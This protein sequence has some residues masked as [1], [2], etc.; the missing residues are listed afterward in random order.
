MRA[1]LDSV[2]LKSGVLCPRCRRVIESGA[3][4][5]K[6]IEVMQHLLELE[7]ADPGFRFLRD[8]NYVKS[9][10]VDSLLLVILDVDAVVSAATLTKLSKVLS[11]RL[12]AKVRV[13]RNSQD[14][15]ALVSQ[16]IAPARMQGIDSVW[17]PDGDVHYVIRISKHDARLLPMRV[18]MLESLLSSMF[19]ATYRVRVL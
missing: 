9:Y 7:E 19:N 15:K 3:V 17:T 11:E 8:T 16:I 12:N 14:P 18:E 10:E 1:P 6:E 5:P 2:C 13:I 4:S